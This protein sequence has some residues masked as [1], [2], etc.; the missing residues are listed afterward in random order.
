MSYRCSRQGTASGTLWND[1]IILAGHNLTNQT[2]GLV[3]QVSDALL[4]GNASGIMG[5]HLLAF[6]ESGVVEP[7]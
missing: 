6:R 1:T 4:G 2:V 7:V 3:D 5:A